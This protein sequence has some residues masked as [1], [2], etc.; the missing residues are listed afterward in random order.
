MRGGCVAR[1]EAMKAQWEQASLTSAQRLI[2]RLA[3]AR[4]GALA[5]AADAAAAVAARAG[6]D[7]ASPP[8]PARL[9]R[10]APAAAAGG[11]QHQVRRVVAA[12]MG[13]PVSSTLN[14]EQTLFFVHLDLGFREY[15]LRVK[16]PLQ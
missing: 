11:P 4:P 5:A 12:V 13:S 2:R 10:A 14:E 6:A 16:G 9:K 1:A 8:L 3:A 7:V 15:G